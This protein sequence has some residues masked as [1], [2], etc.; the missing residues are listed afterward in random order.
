LPGC[1]A[2]HRRDPGAG[3]AVPAGEPAAGVRLSRGAALPGP[4]AAGR[5]PLAERWLNLRN[6]L[7]ASPRFQRWAAGFL[8]TR[9]IARRNT[10]TLFDLC[11]G[12]VY[13]QVLTACI[14]LDVFG[15]LAD[16]PMSQDALAHRLGLPPERARTLLLA[17]VSLDLLRELRDGRFALADLG[18]AVIGNPGIAAMVE[19]HALLYADLADPVSLL[20]GETGPTR[21]ASYWPYAAG[22]TVAPGEAASYSALMGVSQAMI[23]Q[24][25]L[26]ACDF[27]RTRHLMDVGGGE[28][29]FIE[30][31]A[32]HVSG[33]TF[34]LFDLPAVAERAQARLDRTAQA[35]RI[36]CL[37]GDFHDG[38]PQ[39]AD[40]I[41]LVRVIHD[42]D[43]VPAQALLAAAH[44]ALSPG[45]C[46]ILAEPMAGTPGAE[47]IGDAYF[48]FYLMAMGSGRPRRAEELGRMLETAGFATVSERKTR[49]PLLARVLVAQKRGTVP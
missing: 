46:L 22:A 5:R 9:R 35:G 29:V 25:I 27:G 24:D 42:H 19:H 18:A 11:A 38:L 28:G 32:A 12:F 6:R 13:A 14:R 30:T 41:S 4:P 33:P 23:A 44:A 7:V 26:E 34:S 17:A 36:V 37:G 2:A 16:G 47:P 39:G 3:P 48:G 8:P 40:A 45:G 43:D 15:H 1:G 21:L 49:R 20:R 31:A 10:R